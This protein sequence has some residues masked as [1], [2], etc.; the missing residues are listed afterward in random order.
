MSQISDSAAAVRET[1]RAVDGKFGAQ[2]ALESRTPLPT[3]DVDPMD[4]ANRWYAQADELMVQVEG[5]RAR[6]SRHHMQSVAAQALAAEPEAHWLVLTRSCADDGRGVFTADRVV[7]EDGYVLCSR[8]QDVPEMQD[9]AESLGEVEDYQDRP[10]S[11]SWL[12]YAVAGRAQFS[13]D[14]HAAVR[15]QEPQPAPDG[16]SRVTSSSLAPGER[17]EAGEGLYAVESVDPDSGRVRG[18]AV[19]LPGLSIDF[20]PFPVYVRQER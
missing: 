11:A 18:A 10:R 14:V 12:K 3:A 7:T 6:A 5:L 13:V 20:D 19:N 16:Y 1:H 2:P 9:L 4:E 15:D 8:D 17:F